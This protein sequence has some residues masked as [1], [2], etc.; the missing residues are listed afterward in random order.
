MK[1]LGQITALAFGVLF[2]GALAY[3]AYLAYAWFVALFAELDSQV[4]AVTAIACVVVLAA[5]WLV[6]RSARGAARDRKAFAVR[7][8]R[9][10]TY[11]LFVDYWVNAL[12][13]P[14]GAQ[15]PSAAERADKLRT[16][17][18][19]LA[20]YGTAAVMRAHSTLVTLERDKGARHPEL[21]KQLGE[22]LV[23]LRKDLG[24]ETPP[25]LE[26][27]LRRLLLPAMDER[28]A[29]TDDGSARISP[30]LTPHS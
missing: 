6:A 19:L 18:R 25:N 15:E 10:A 5:A 12:S 7:E 13:A 30:L 2:L 26:Q 22:A 8:E 29:T 14:P 17:E 23:A 24:V 4:A 21:R 11:Q 27:D 16:L 3:G 9:A 1:L 20:L 28:R